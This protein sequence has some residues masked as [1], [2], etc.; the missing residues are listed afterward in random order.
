MAR[1]SAAAPT[2]SPT[3]RSA[4][5]S[6]TLSSLAPASYWRTGLGFVLGVLTFAGMHSLPYFAVDL[7]TAIVVGVVAALFAETVVVAATLGGAVFV[8][9]AALRLPDVWHPA[10]VQPSLA[11]LVGWALLAAGAGAACVW[12]F[13][14]AGAGRSIAV[15]LLV[16]VFVANMWV[17]ALVFNGLTFSDPTTGAVLPTV[18]QQ[19][20]GQVPASRQ[21][22]DSSIYVGVVSRMRAGED[23]YS[24][25]SAEMAKIDFKVSHVFNYRLPM[26]FW[27]WSALPSATWA[28]PAFLLLASLAVASLPWALRGL[29]DPAVTVFACS[30]LAAYQVVTAVQLQVLTL[31]PW[32]GALT[33]LAFSA[34]AL[35]FSG[36]RWKTWTVVAVC[37]ALL[38]ALTREIAVVVL[39]A[40]AASALWPGPQRRFRLSAWGAGLAVFGVAYALHWMR[41]VPLLSSA[42]GSMAVGSVHDAYLALIFG[43]PT[44]GSADWFAMFFAVAGILGAF[45]IVPRELRTFTGAT[46]LVS[47]LAFSVVTNG[48]RTGVVRINYW[49]ELIVPLMIGLSAVAF[50]VVPTA[51]PVLR[52]AGA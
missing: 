43:W 18:W 19:L 3:S 47:L 28:V 50:R 27:L 20:D 48:A 35:S 32:A 24:A 11:A 13:K 41:V 40:G 8:A 5:R 46:V 36:R 34:C 30:A 38:A 6:A 29:V 42:G 1:R 37:C 16:V 49:G 2:R 17:T 7:Q 33:V 15:W 44:A 45:L 31:E 23:Y 21:G 25:F 52:E 10:A 12:I 26:P 51:R 14:R 9:G 22:S 39:V 4:T